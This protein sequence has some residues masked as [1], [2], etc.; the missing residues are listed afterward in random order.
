M[1][2]FNDWLVCGICTQIKQK[3]AN[4]D[5]LISESDAEFETTGLLKQVL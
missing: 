4:F 2:P 1:P 3:V 5:V